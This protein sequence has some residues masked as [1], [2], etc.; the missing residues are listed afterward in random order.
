[1]AKKKQP[2]HIEHNMK[3]FK[4]PDGT[5]FWARDRESALLYN[6]K[7]NGG[8]AKIGTDGK[9]FHEKGDEY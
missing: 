5:K 4:L 2:F 8:H 7:V 9:Y 3:E 1:M 6:Q